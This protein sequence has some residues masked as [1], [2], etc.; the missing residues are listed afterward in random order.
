MIPRNFC[1]NKE[2][3]GRFYD[4]LD[5]VCEACSDGTHCNDCAITK[6]REAA[7]VEEEADEEAGHVVSMLPAHA[8]FDCFSI[9]PEA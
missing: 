6:I 5:T 3:A 7:Y 2:E 1:I 4:A 9:N 8:Y